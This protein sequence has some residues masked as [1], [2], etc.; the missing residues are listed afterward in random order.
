MFNFAQTL[1]SKVTNDQILD[2]LRKRY[3]KSIIYV[4]IF[5]TH[6]F[7]ISL[8]PIGPCIHDYFLIVDQYWRCAY[9][10]ESIQAN[11]YIF[12]FLIMFVF[13]MLS[14]MIAYFSVLLS[15][16]CSC[17]L[18]PSILTTPLFSPAQLFIIIV[19]WGNQ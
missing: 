7:N 1:L 14:M 17:F 15:V 12:R 2:N 16:H 13:P 9:L 4:C 5:T 10:S 8:V 19:L 6:Q 18:I 3:E 11:S